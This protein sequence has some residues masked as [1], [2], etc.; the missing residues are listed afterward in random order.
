MQKVEDR[1]VLNKHKPRRVFPQ[2]IF[3]V[4]QGLFLISTIRVS[5]RYFEGCNV[6][7]AGPHR[8]VALSPLFNSSFSPYIK[9][10]VR[11]GH[12]FRG[13]GEP[14]C[15]FQILLRLLPHAFQ[16][17]GLRQIE[18]GDEVRLRLCAHL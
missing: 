1:L 15:L 18:K 4:F 16:P 6:P 5:T 17:V 13:A 12:C 14:Q 10:M 7:F 2:C 3:Q 8:G 11:C 9:G